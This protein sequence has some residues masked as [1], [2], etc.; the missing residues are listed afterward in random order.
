MASYIIKNP[1]TIY[2]KMEAKDI[3]EDKKKGGQQD[4]V[5]DIKAIKSMIKSMNEEWSK[6]TNDD[7]GLEKLVINIINE[8]SPSISNPDC[9]Y[10]ILLHGL[11][12]KD[13]YEDFEKRIKFLKMVSFVNL[14]GC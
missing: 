3:K 5:P 13:I 7:S 10:F 6:N 11:Y 12:N 8:K 9:K 4:F 2:A 14:I 1:P